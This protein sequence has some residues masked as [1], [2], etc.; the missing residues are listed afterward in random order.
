MNDDYSFGYC[1]VCD[2][3]K[4]LYNDKCS[5]CQ[6]VKE[7]DLPDFMNDLFNGGYKSYEEKQNED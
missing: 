5:D 3:L 7:N 2:K 1:K 6:H 4:P